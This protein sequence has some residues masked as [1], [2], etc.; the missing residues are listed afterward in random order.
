VLGVVGLAFGAGL[1]ALLPVTE[2]ESE[3]LGDV[4]AELQRN[5]SDFATEQ[6]HQA[7]VLAERVT[8]AIAQEMQPQGLIGDELKSQIAQAGKTWWN[9]T[10]EVDER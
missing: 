6:T 3:L 5:V 2:K 8:H 4:S 1:A 7:R 9:P 10:T